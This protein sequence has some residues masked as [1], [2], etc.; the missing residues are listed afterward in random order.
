MPPLRAHAA[1]PAPSLPAC[2]APVAVSTRCPYFFSSPSHDPLRLRH[3][4]LPKIRVA[5]RPAGIDQG[6]ANRVSKVV[7]RAG[8]MIDGIFSTSRRSALE[9]DQLPAQG[10]IVQQ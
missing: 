5:E 2:G 4:C 6:A 8:A 3:L 1:L 7:F 10:I 9:R